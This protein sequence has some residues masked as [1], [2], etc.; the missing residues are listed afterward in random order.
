MAPLSGIARR[1]GSQ[2]VA[3]AL[4]LRSQAPTAPSVSNALL[5]APIA[6]PAWAAQPVAS[7]LRVVRALRGLLAENAVKRTS[8]VATP[9]RRDLAA[10]RFAERVDAGV[11]VINDVI[12]PTADPRLPFG[13]RRASGFGVTRGREGLLE[14]TQVKA[15]ALRAGTFRPHL[16]PA[17]P[18]DADLF[19]AYLG[20]VHG[21]GL[22]G[23][24]RVLLCLVRSLIRLGRKSEQE[25]A[26]ELL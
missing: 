14:M 11:V 15:I 16:D 26:E 6:Q 9:W 8:E 22:L 1:V 5:Q 21:R 4:D 7:R 2:P 17:M 20:A 12:V 13:G 19:R 3:P 25:R 23:R 10:A 24:V 18:R